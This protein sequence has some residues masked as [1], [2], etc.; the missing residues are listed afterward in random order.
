MSEPVRVCFVC[1]G[2][3]CRSPTAEGIMLQLVE[4]A[5]LSGRIEIDS[6]GTGGYHIGEQADPRSRAEARRRGVDLPSQA[7]MF[8]P[9]DFARF[10]YVV[11]MDR[12]NL[13]D[14]LA[15]ASDAQQEAKLHLLRSFDPASAKAG[16][17]DVP[18]PY[19]GDGDQ[20]FARVF[21]ICHAGCVGLLAQIRQRHGL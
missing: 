5:G 3:I 9:S 19:F 12:R 17:L 16:D 2:N 6:A 14:L 7:R 15:M 1:L 8:L 18:D 4:Q 21:D 13:G 11:A 10:D 20:G